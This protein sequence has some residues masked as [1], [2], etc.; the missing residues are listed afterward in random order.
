MQT[1]FEPDSSYNAPPVLTVS[2]LNAQVARL[3]ERSF[4][5]TWMVAGTWAIDRYKKTISLIAK[6]LKVYNEKI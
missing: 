4:P 2:A 6:A 5:L 1:M 3:L